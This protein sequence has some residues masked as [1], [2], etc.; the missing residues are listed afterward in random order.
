M[1]GPPPPISTRPSSP[2]QH[3]RKERDETRRAGNHAC[4]PSIGPP[5]RALFGGVH[6]IPIR[7]DSQEGEREREREGYREGEA[8]ERRQR[9][10]S[11]GGRS[12]LLPSPSDSRCHMCVREKSLGSILTSIFLSLDLVVAATDLLIYFIIIFFAFFFFCGWINQVV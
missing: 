8:R 9:W 4:Q 7:R 1:P 6:P 5:P 11:R 10:P 3:P 12:V 2:T